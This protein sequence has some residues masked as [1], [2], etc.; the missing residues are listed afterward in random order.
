MFEG[1]A[2]F[3]DVSRPGVIHQGLEGV[4]GDA[5]DR[6]MIL[7]RELIDEVADKQRE[8]LAAFAQRR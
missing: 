8:I 1:V 7:S 5:S 2:E 3:S 6:A 4:A